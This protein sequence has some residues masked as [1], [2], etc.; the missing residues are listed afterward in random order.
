MTGGTE[1]EGLKRNGPS[2]A[3]EWNQMRVWMRKDTG[4]TIMSRFEFFI[5]S[6]WRPPEQNQV[7]SNLVTG[8][9]RTWDQT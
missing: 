1:K 8:S 9:F 2:A 7:Q 4:N 3:D 5:D 6:S